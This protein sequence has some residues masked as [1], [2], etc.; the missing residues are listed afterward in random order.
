M[1]FSDVRGF[2]YK[3][4]NESY[5]ILKCKPNIIYALK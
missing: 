2:E 3:Q 4:Q 5:F 1:E